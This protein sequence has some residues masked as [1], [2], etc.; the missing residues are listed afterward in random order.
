ML[1]LMTTRNGQ[2]LLHSNAFRRFTPQS[3]RFAYYLHQTFPNTISKLFLL[4][5]KSLILNKR[6]I[7]P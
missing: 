2:K 1:P 6:T 3:S 5:C 7:C 4:A